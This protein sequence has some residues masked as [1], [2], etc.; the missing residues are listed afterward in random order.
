VRGLFTAILLCL[1]TVAASSS[2]ARDKPAVLKTD[3]GFDAAA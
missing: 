2:S 3:L 1:A